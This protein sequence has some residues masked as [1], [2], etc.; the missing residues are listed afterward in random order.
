MTIYVAKK[1]WSWK[2]VEVCNVIIFKTFLF[3][4]QLNKCVIVN[5]ENWFKQENQSPTFRSMDPGRHPV[6]SFCSLLNKLQTDA[7][8]MCKIII[9]TVQLQ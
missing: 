9:Q 8:G 4:S 7:W 2:T 3:W 5:P 6:E 1:V